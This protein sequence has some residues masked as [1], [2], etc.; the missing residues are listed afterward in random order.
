MREK[1]QRPDP[2]KSLVGFVVGDVSY[3][4]PIAS[5]KE[6]VNPAPLTSLPHLP[7]AVAGVADHRG[8]VIVVVDLRVRFGLGPAP[9][10]SRT[11]WVL[12]TVGGKVVGL[13][14][15]HVTDV[16]G[17]G[18]EQVRPAP[19]LGAGTDARG[20]TGVISHAGALTFVLDVGKFEALTDQVPPEVFQMPI[21]ARTEA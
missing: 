10:Q 2:N 8:D 16:F 17:T 21:E 5:V 6:I 20:I 1:K 15:D 4:V 14:V 12:V 11:K 3:A 18:G 19:A 9:D 7:L 13:I